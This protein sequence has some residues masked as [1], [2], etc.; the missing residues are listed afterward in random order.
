[1]A[2]ARDPG[3]AGSESGSVAAALHI[4]AKEYRMD[5]GST[6]TALAHATALARKLNYDVTFP[7]YTIES[8]LSEPA[9]PER[10]EDALTPAS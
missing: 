10:D 8:A 4:G 6:A 2:I 5:C 1:M 7:Y 9:P 3:S